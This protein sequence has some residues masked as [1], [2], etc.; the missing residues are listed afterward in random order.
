MRKVMFIVIM[1]SVFFLCSCDSPFGEATSVFTENSVTIKLDAG[2]NM[3]NIPYTGISLSRFENIPEIVQVSIWDTTQN[4]YITVS[5]DVK[6]GRF[7]GSLN[8]SPLDGLMI[9]SKTD[10]TIFLNNLGTRVPITNVSLV[11]GFNLV[12]ISLKTPISVKQYILENNHIQ[13]I[14]KYNKSNYLSAV[15]DKKGN[16]LLQSSDFLVGEEGSAYYIKSSVA[17][18]RFCIDTDNGLDYTKNGAVSSDGKM[19]SDYCDNEFEVMENYCED[20]LYK[21][22]RHFCN[23]VCKAGAC[24]SFKDAKMVGP[25][26]TEG[27]SKC[28]S[29]KI[30]EKC[31]N[32]ELFNATCND[33]C[34]NGVCNHYVG[35]PVPVC[36]NSSGDFYPCSAEE[37]AKLEKAELIK[38]R[39]PPSIELL[40]KCYRERDKAIIE[41]TQDY[42]KYEASSALA[43]VYTC[44]KDTSICGLSD[45]YVCDG[46][47]FKSYMYCNKG[48]VNGKCVLSNETVDAK[49]SLVTATIV[50]KREYAHCSEY[51]SGINYS[52]AALTEAYSDNIKESFIDNCSQS[53]LKEYFCDKGPNYGGYVI[54]ETQYKCPHGCSASGGACREQSCSDGDGLN[55]YNKSSVTIKDYSGSVVYTDSCNDKV[56][57]NMLTEYSC[58]KGNVKTNLYRCPGG[59]LDGACVSCLDTDSGRVLNV[60]GS[61]WVTGNNGPVYDSC[62]SNMSMTLKE[63]TCDNG[64]VVP[65]SYTCGTVCYDGACQP[66]TCTDVNGFVTIKYG[67]VYNETFEDKCT[68]IR[69]DKGVPIYNKVN[70][71]CN[72]SKSDGSVPLLG[73][74]VTQGC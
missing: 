67:T 55:Y 25:A 27:Q 53:Y 56:N 36:T 22:E 39:T 46:T 59:C 29:K 32:G 4:K 42:L 72:A 45:V 52:I 60:K 9:K 20:G 49:N 16:I 17:I 18:N 5:R 7:R 21:V 54:K 26:C 8:I 51:D 65:L 64:R 61:V 11:K 37:K 63:L 6:T 15:K 40:S 62:T 3:I 71:Y 70:Y 30:M 41:C 28:I 47:G 50:S 1:L 58:D 69:W 19:V 31:M 57:R 73:T 24:V 66:G 23:D 12:P 68:F 48:C 2:Y 14:Y 13:A 35:K 38:K 10:K 44:T 43:T 33:D 74:T 34:R